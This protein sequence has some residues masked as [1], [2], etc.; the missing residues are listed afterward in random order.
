VEQELIHSRVLEARHQAGD[1][2]RRIGDFREPAQ[3]PRWPLA[4]AFAIGLI[5]GAGGYHVF[6]RRSGIRGVAWRT[7]K[8]ANRGESD[9]GEAEVDE[10][11]STGS[12]RMNT[13]RRAEA[14]VT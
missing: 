8:F 12:H 9:L 1:V 14:E 11:L 2:L 6:V 13:R 5:A 10:R 3:S 7:L 4:V